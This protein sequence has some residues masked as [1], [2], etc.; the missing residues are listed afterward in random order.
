MNPPFDSPLTKG[1][2]GEY[3]LLCRMSFLLPL[4]LALACAQVAP[5]SSSAPHSPFPT[6]LFEYNREVPTKRHLEG[7]RTLAGEW[8]S[9]PLLAPRA[10]GLNLLMYE[11]PLGASWQMEIEGTLVPIE[12]I[13]WWQDSENWLCL[14]LEGEHLVW[15]CKY[16][17]LPLPEQRLGVGERRSYRLVITRAYSQFKA[18]L[19]AERISH[20]TMNLPRR[21]QVGLR[22]QNARGRGYYLEH[23]HGI[24]YLRIEHN[25]VVDTRAQGLVPFTVDQ[26]DLQAL[27][28]Y[29]A[30]QCARDSRIGS[31]WKQVPIVVATF[32]CLD[33][34][35]PAL[36]EKVAEDLNTLLAQAGFTLVERRNLTAVVKELKLQ[37]SGLTDTQTVQNIGRLVGARFILVGTLT[38]E[39]SHV[40]L[41]TRLIETATGT[42]FLASRHRVRK[43]LLGG[44]QS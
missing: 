20:Y 25:E 10:E 11:K 27:A 1:G 37:M 19:N 43:V 7:W 30:Q 32:E 29:L 22:C 18:E 16:N 14:A 33:I 5:E 34:P 9:T 31:E 4:S 42:T 41:N 6:P 38:D 8:S 2:R 13:V 26:N 40:I 12:V 21:G 28:S 17:G 24:R 35:D 44:R 15:R 3:A 23:P 39:E 36:G